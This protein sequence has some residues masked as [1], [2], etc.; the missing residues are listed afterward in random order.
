MTRQSDSALSTA[1]QPPGP[2]KELRIGDHIE[3][4]YVAISFHPEQG[5][6]WT[7]STKFRVAVWLTALLCAA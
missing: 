3:R 1:D 6:I 5:R 7:N 4:R 2:K